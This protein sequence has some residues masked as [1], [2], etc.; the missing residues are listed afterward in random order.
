VK[1]TA[2]DVKP[3]AQ[4]GCDD[5]LAAFAAKREV[6]TAELYQQLALDLN[7]SPVYA[8]EKQA[9]GKS[10]SSHN[11][12]NRSVRW[13]VQTLKRL[14]VVEQMHRGKWRISGHAKDALTEAPR[15]QVMV[16]FE[17][18]LGVA[19]WAN[20]EDV[21]TALQENIAL[22]FT[23]PPYPLAHERQYG[24]VNQTK[25]VDWL[26]SMVEPIVKNLV[27][28]GSIVLNLS[29]DVF[30]PGLPSRS[31]YL[32]RLTLA[33]CDRLGLSLMDRFVWENPCK[34][35][36]PYH[37][38]SKN[39]FQCNAGYEP[40]LWFTN[41]PSKV[42]S[43]NRRVLEPHTETQQMLIDAGGEQRTRKFSGGAYRLKQGSFANPTDGRIPRNMLRIPH[44]CAD[45]KPAREFAKLHGIPAHPAPMP[46]KLSDFFVEFLTRPGDLVVDQFGGIGTTA[47]SAEVKGR[48]WVTTERC[49]EYIAAAAER[50]KHCAGFAAA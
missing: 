8:A 49:R 3:A 1:S 32:E 48:R 36:S 34:P 16:A 18:D 44:S 12:F 33:L 30:E 41:D 35:P 24:N 14:G 45:Q 9:V 5:V 46:K 7:L 2:T 4:M 11:L 25:Y 50:F 31:L 15:K 27:P 22:S 19:L 26:C 39:R 28:G 20:S 6:T 40:V 38:A 42:R 13:H 21:F 10:G 17:T 23:S 43:D 29:N 47:K 37:W